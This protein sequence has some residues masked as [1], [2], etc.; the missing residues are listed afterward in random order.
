MRKPNMTIEQALENALQYLEASGVTGGDV[1]DDLELA[2]G[3]LRR[4]YPKIAQEEL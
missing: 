4:Q 3:R 2:I 1:H